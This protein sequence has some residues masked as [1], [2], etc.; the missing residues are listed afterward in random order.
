[1]RHRLR[2]QL[3]HQVNRCHVRHVW[4]HRRAGTRS[5]LRHSRRFDR[6]LV[7]EE[8]DVRSGPG[9][10]RCGIWYRGFLTTLHVVA[11]R[12]RMEGHVA[13]LRR[14]V[15]EYVRLWDADEESRL[16]YRRRV[17]TKIY[18]TKESALY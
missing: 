1:M 10:Q 6:V 3:L 5:L 8:E 18:K 12:V 9:R 16:D 2:H 4:R 11:L 17:S 14:T 15:R 13:D 7:R